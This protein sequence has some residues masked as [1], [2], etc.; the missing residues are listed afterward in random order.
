M[1]RERRKGK[2]K[3]KTKVDSL[4]VK[5]R[6]A[7]LSKDPYKFDPVDK[8]VWKEYETNKNADVIKFIDDHYE[9]SYWYIGTDSQQYTKPLRCI[10]TT[11]LVAH[12]VD[13][14]SGIGKGGSIIRYVDRRPAIPLEAMSA[15]LTVEVQRSIEICKFLEENLLERS[16]DENE[17]WKNIVGISIDCNKDIKHKSARYKDALVGMVVAY[18]WNAF[19]KPDAWA[20]TNVADKKC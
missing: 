2:G 1:A 17:Y 3:S 13:P 11:V 4:K 10:F 14:I 8:W 6:P 16:D 18:G 15:R 12:M 7:Y 9:N 5:A 19:I 20:S